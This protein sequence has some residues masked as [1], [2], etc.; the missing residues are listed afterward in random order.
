[1]GEN[2]GANNP[3]AEG[4]SNRPS[5]SRKGTTSR[6]RFRKTG[7]FSLLGQQWTSSP[8]VTLSENDQ[9]MVREALDDLPEGWSEAHE[10]VDS[11]IEELHETL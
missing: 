6:S 5:A 1:M 7:L 2:K 4:R 10:D 3:A 8:P 9:P 11:I